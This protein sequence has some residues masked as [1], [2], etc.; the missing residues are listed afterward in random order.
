[1]ET[2]DAAETKEVD[3][4]SAGGMRGG[5]DAVCFVSLM[6]IRIAN[7]LGSERIT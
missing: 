1:L 2:Q 5:E 6:N 3:P 7:I 4:H